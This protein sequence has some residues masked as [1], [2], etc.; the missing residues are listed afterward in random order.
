[1][2]TSLADRTTP[3]PRSKYRADRIRMRA[4]SGAGRG[5]AA[6]TMVDPLEAR[7]LMAN[8]LPHQIDVTLFRDLNRNGQQD[9]DEGGLEGWTVNSPDLRNEVGDIAGANAT[10]DS[11]GHVTLTAYGDAEGSDQWGAYI[12]VPGSSRYWT[13]NAIVQD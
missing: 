10:T 9:A 12:D 8:W 7:R 2:P 5:A 3:S 13:T 4:H 11:A 6:S 1:M